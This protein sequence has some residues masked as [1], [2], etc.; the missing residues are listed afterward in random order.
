MWGGRGVTG[1]CNS[2]VPREAR[3]VHGGQPEVGVVQSSGD[4]WLGAV[5]AVGAVRAMQKKYSTSGLLSEAA[6]MPTASAV[7]LGGGNSKSQQLSF[8]LLAMRGKYK[9]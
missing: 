2:G 6:A 4:A 9:Q 5:K 1:L 7:S 8:L 3:I